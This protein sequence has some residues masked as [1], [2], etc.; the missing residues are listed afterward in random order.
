MNRLI[1]G[2][3]LGLL[4]GA[5]AWCA[6]L[7]ATSLLP[8]DGSVSVEEFL[9]GIVLSSGMGMLIGGSAVIEMERATS[10]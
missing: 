3:L 9:F 7:V 2:W 4:S 6:L 10:R 5:G 8:H 1:L